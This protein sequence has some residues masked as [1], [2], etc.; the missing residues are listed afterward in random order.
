MLQVTDKICGWYKR[1]SQPKITWWW[2]NVVDRAIKKKET[3]WEYDDTKELYQIAR[4][5][6]KKQVYLARGETDKKRIGQCSVVRTRLKV[7]PI[8]K[9][10]ERESGCH[11]RAMCPHG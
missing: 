7:F 5:E 6:A 10:C 1:P 8:A 11:R 4:R 9:Q 3:D 2:I